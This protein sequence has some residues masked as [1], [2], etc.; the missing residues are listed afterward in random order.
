MSA[1]NSIHNAMT[2][3][4]YQSISLTLFYAILYLMSEK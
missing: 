1:L 4:R 3:L 2:F